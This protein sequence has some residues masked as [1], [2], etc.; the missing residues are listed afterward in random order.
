MPNRRRDLGVAASLKERGYFAGNHG[1][2]HRQRDSG[3]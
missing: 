3:R 2:Q 1:H